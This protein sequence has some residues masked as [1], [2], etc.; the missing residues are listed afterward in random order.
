MSARRV[1]STLS[2]VEMRRGDCGELPVGVYWPAG[3]RR[4]R[5]SSRV[6]GSL[7]QT[8]LSSD[9]A[10]GWLRTA[11]HMAC[12]I[13]SPISWSRRCALPSKV[14]CM[15]SG[16]H[17]CGHAKTATGKIHTWALAWWVGN[18][19]EIPKG[20]R[21]GAKLQAQQRQGSSADHG[22]TSI[23]LDAILCLRC[24]LEAAGLGL[25]RAPSRCPCI[26]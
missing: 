21:P 6:G 23:V 26:P 15:I 24:A 12:R 19:K 8:R 17:Q 25:L 11:S 4:R 18:Q 9:S 1:S 7:L 5:L 16:R 14:G 3:D 20:C 10:P 13:M 2:P 22:T